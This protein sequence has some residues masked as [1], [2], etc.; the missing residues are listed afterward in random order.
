MDGLSL[1]SWLSSGRL[2][3]LNSNAPRRPA[4]ATLDVD[5]VLVDTLLEELLGSVW[6]PPALEVG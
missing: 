5:S 2:A 6:Q 1:T 4:S 3:I